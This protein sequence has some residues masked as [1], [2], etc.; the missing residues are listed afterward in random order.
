MQPARRFTADA[1]RLREPS[2]RALFGVVG[3]LLALAVVG[4]VAVKQLNAVGR[5]VGSAAQVG[6]DASAAP[7]T[8]AAASTGTWVEQSK[9]IQDKVRSDVAKALE[10][11]A[12]R[13]EEAAK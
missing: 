9:Q 1:P 7:Q 6:A 8:P 10:Q 3:L 4:I 5:S 12:A 13:T 2:L 11:G